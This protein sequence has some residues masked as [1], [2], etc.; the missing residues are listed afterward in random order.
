M[1]ITGIHLL[2][3]KF[4]SS[5]ENGIK[6]PERKKLINCNTK[7]LWWKW[8][9]T[10]TSRGSQAIKL[11]NKKVSYSIYSCSLA[12][13]N[14]NLQLPYKQQCVNLFVI[15]SLCWTCNVVV[16]RILIVI[17]TVFCICSRFKNWARMH[18]ELIG[19]KKRFVCV[20][21][22]YKQW[23]LYCRILNFGEQPFWTI[24]FISFFKNWFCF[25]IAFALYASVFVGSINP[26]NY[27][28]NLYY[29]Y[30]WVNILM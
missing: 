8:F 14:V 27:V 6:W 17:I 23:S 5:F 11:C 22:P 29:N 19:Y 15:N 13:I 28:L 26:L 10:L 18:R 24:A 1:E 4:H 12:F 3:S 20:L 21:E 2:C 25:S 9:V 30:V 7:K 16:L